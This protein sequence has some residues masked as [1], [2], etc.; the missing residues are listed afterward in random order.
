MAMER[1]NDITHVIQLAIAPAIILLVF[2]L[3]GEPRQTAYFKNNLP[4]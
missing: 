2:E 3:A 4:N 1:I